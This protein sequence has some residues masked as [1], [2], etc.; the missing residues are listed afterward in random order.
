MIIL[1]LGGSL[2]TDKSKQFEVRADVLERLAEEIKESSEEELIIVHGGGSFGHPVAS[3]YNLQDGFK[4][5]EQIEGIVQTRKS[6]GELSRSVI[7]T[8]HEQKLPVV[9][10]QPS[11][12]ITCKAGRIED[13]DAGVVKKFLELGTIPVLFGDVV[14]D[15]ELGFCILSGDQ[16]TTHLALKFD[17]DRVILAADVDGVYDRNPKK[18]D[19][20]KLITEINCTEGDILDTLTTEDGDVTGGIKGK[21]E[22][23]IMLAKNGVPSQVINAMVAGRLKK[24]L[25]GE[26]VTGTVVK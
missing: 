17:A 3:K 26:D 9:A 12:N 6:M 15:K 18:F 14:L 21:I 19:D 23:L 25:S 16:I 7:N 2:I 4:N 8:F 13:M 1:K 5:K 20:A 10:I 11:A 22:E 24:A